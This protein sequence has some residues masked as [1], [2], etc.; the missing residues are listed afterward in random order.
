MIEGGAI[1][2]L[3]KLVDLVSSAKTAE[4][5]AATIDSVKAEIGTVEA[6]LRFVETQKTEAIE[7]FARAEQALADRDERLARAETQLRDAQEKLRVYESLTD[8]VEWKGALIKRRHPDGFHDV[9]FCMKCR[10][11]L[12]NGNVYHCRACQ[13]SSTFSHHTFLVELARLTNSPA[14]PEPR[15]HSNPYP[16]RSPWTA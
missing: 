14:P 3:G 15:Q 12:A 16:R 2:A 9:P 5:F 4:A 10:M 6:H 11:A 8:F 13:W 7:R 1:F